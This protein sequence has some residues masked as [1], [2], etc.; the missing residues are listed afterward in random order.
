MNEQFGRGL[1]LALLTVCLWGAQYPIGK[2]AME[3]IDGV[4]VTAIRYGLAAVVLAL[5]LRIA[6]GRAAFDYRGRFPLLALAGTFGFAAS[7]L[8]VFLGLSVTRPEHAAVLTALQPSLTAI[9]DWW[10][11]GRRP[12]QATLVCLAIAFVGAVLVITRGDPAHA[13]VGGELLG[14]VLVLVGGSLWVVYTMLSERIAFG[15]ALRYTTLTLL[16]GAFVILLIAFACEQLGWLEAPTPETL[17][18]HLPSLAYLGLGGIVIAMIA[19]N[20][21]LRRIGALNTMLFMSLV[22]VV[23]FAIRLAQGAR[24]TAIEI[25]GALLVVGALVANNLFL[26]RA[27]LNAS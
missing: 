19:W 25:A 13:L 27:R 12:R 20:A 16:P 8:C 18:L 11:R 6:E 22:P 26:R 1:A 10:L 2:S 23:T 3:V 9:A 14:N 4:H 24:F 5:W 15:S 21:S 17:A 7:G